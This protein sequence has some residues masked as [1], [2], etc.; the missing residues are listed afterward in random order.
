MMWFTKNRNRFLSDEA[1]ER[2]T[3][4]IRV[5]ERAT[6]GE[7]RLFIESHC[8]YMDPVRRAAEIFSHLK[9]HHT[10]NRNGVLIYIAYLDKDF[11]LYAASALYQKV[12]ADFLAREGKQLAAYFQQKAFEEGIMKCIESTGKQLNMHFPWHGEQKNELP[13]EI[14]FGR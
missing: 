2:L 11:A 14:V 13:D 1:I 5:Q 7:I 4:C 8:P 12:S 3:E 9:M 6:T 10:S